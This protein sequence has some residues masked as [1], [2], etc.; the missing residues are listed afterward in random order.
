MQQTPC[1]T[2]GGQWRRDVQDE[3][4]LLL[5]VLKRMHVHMG[6]LHVRRVRLLLL[7]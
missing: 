5:R 3:F 2:H 4:L 7:G 6:V 1:S